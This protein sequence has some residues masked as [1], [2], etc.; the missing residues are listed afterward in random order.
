[1]ETKE[2]KVVAPEGYEIDKENST[3]ECIK[4]KLIKEEEGRTD[5]HY[6]K[7]ICGGSA[8]TNKE[9]ERGNEIQNQL[10]S[11]ETQ[12]KQWERAKAFSGIDLTDAKEDPHERWDSSGLRVD[13][14][15]FESVKSS[16]LITIQ[17][18]ITKLQKEFDEL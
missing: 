9:L 4:F 11:L 12:K 8:M 10:R 15:N 2:L 18:R 13:L 3:F 6:G 17:N 5:K 1:M 7:N 14:V 16:V